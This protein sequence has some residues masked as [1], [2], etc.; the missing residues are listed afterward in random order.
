[1]F[2]K[3]LLFT[4]MSS[5]LLVGACGSGEDSASTEDLSPGE[6]LYQ[7]NSCMGCHGRALEGGT[8]PN[9]QDVGNRYTQD[10]IESIIVNGKGQMRGGLI[11]D[12]EDLDT[13]VEW[14]SSQ[15]E[16]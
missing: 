12:Q 3:L 2:K 14:L 15:T 8:G 7:A 9:L 1:M 6:E 11:T 5:V 10:E 13:I 4:G 16:E